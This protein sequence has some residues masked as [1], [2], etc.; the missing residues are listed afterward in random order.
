MERWHDGP[1]GLQ[2]ASP[3]LGRTQRMTVQTEPPLAREPLTAVPACGALFRGLERGG[4]GSRAHEL[5]CQPLC[6]AGEPT[7]SWASGGLWKSHHLMPRGCEI[8]EPREA[9]G[10]SSTSRTTS[11]L[12]A[13]DSMPGPWTCPLVVTNRKFLHVALK[14]E[15]QLSCAHLPPPGT[16]F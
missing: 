9:K 7:P 13:Q 10:Q 6:R 2:V 14:V 1:V 4:G 11:L 12:M 8:S 15:S 3:G 16:S 5:Y